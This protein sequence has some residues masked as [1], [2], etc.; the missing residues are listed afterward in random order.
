MLELS[1][2]V[3]D[4]AENSTRA[5]AKHILIAVREDSEQDRLTLEIRDDGAGMTEEALA[6]ALD[7][8]YTTKKVRRV[9]LGLPMLAEAA[10]KSGGEL[11]LESR[12]GEGTR[13]RVTFGLTHIDRQPLG[14]I[15]GTLVTLLTGHP[16]TELVYRH[17]RD[18]RHFVLD[19]REIREEIGDIP[20]NHP[21][22]LSWVRLQVEEGLTEIEAGA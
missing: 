20:L 7:P 21:E 11:T 10:G 15:A 17:E 1:L 9:G 16:Q 4:I 22:I 12:P 2:H 13:V 6:K 8:F 5:E 3:L 18:G 19:T 14:D